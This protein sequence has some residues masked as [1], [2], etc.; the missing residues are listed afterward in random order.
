MKIRR[1]LLLQILPLIPIL[2]LARAG[3]SN[4]AVQ[5]LNLHILINIVHLGGVH[6]K[7][8]AHTLLLTTLQWTELAGTVSLLYG[9]LLH[10]GRD[11]ARDTSPPPLPTH[12]LAVASG[13]FTSCL[14]SL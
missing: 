7:G 11:T 13:I 6:I 2:F 9:M 1:N 4:Q 8:E 3:G 12:T 14:D 5:F 10:Q